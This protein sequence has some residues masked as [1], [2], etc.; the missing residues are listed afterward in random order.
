MQP[1]AAGMQLDLCTDFLLTK[2]NPEYVKDLHHGRS[3]L[4]VGHLDDHGGMQVPE[5]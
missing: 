1:H 2:A 4:F 3:T 5:V